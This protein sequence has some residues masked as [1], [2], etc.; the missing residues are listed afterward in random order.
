M[1]R[2]QLI[3]MARRNMAHVNAGTINQEPDVLRVPAT[4]YYDQDRWQAEMAAVF[5]RMPL[6]LALSC[7][8]PAPGDFKTMNVARVPLLLVRQEDGTVRALVNSCSH[9]GAVIELAGSG[10]AK[11]FTCPYHAWSYDSAGNLQ[12]VY[13]EKDFGTID[14][15]CNGLVQLPVAERAGMIWVT[16]DPKSALDIGAFLCGYDELLG[17]FGFAD[18]HLFSRRSIAGPN[19]K[20]AYDGYMDLYHLPIL[21][22]NSFGPNMSNRAI[23]TA[24]GPHQRVS[25]PDPGLLSLDNVPEDEWPT[26]RLIGGVWTIFPH[27]SIASFDGGGP[28]VMVSQLFPG[29]SPQES[30]TVQSYLMKNPP[31]DAAAAE[32]ATKQFDLLEYVV[33]EEDYATGLRQQGALMGGTKQFV[34]FG[35]NEGG[36]QRFHGWLEK[37]LATADADLPALFAAHQQPAI[38]E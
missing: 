20:V 22:K 10:N 16:L 11:R 23:Y 33:R 37:L 14:K 25:S 26:G 31:V 35:R 36:G 18:W 21:H 38:G 17:H 3:E 5:K 15:S 1:S 9:R 29:N 2:A 6:M 13:V 30:V 4:N 7:E 28:S 27:I 12:S 32:A 34:M 24:F 8:M 19:W